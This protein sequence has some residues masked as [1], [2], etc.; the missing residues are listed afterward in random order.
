MKAKLVRIGMYP[1]E[2]FPVAPPRIPA[3]RPPITFPPILL[4]RPVVCCKIAVWPTGRIIASARYQRVVRNL[5]TTRV[6]ATASNM[7]T[8][9]SRQRCPIANRYGGAYNLRHLAQNA[10]SQHHGG[11]F[12]GGTSEQASTLHSDRNS[13]P[14]PPGDSAL[15][16][17]LRCK[18][19]SA[20]RS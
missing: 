2:S 18:V 12:S 19:N 13:R 6:V 3:A 17:D 8:A 11:P 16:Q 14:D 7:V 4:S 15:Y 10:Q 20:K 9:I 1:S 5:V